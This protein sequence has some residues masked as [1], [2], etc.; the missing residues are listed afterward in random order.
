MGSPLE[1]NF[2]RIVTSNLI[3]IIIS[4]LK[5]F[6]FECGSF[7]QFWSSTNTNQR[8]LKIT[9]FKIMA[10]LQTFN[11]EICTFLWAIK[12]VFRNTPPYQN[13]SASK[14]MQQYNNSRVPIVKHSYSISKECRKNI[15][16]SFL[17][18]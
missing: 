10:L 11:T 15:C 6:V 5:Y 14:P 9:A 7:C 8:Q 1:H 4:I 12:I 16:G 2:N 17:P 3:L 18:R 13:T